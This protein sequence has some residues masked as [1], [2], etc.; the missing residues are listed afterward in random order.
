MRCPPSVRWRS[1]VDPPSGV[2]ST[3]GVD[4]PPRIWPAGAVRPLL[5]PGPPLLRVSRDSHRQVS[6]AGP[7]GHRAACLRWPVETGPPAPLAKWDVPHVLTPSWRLVEVALGLAR[8]P[9]ERSCWFWS[10]RK[11]CL[12]VLLTPDPP[13]HQQPNQQEHASSRHRGPKD[14]AIHCLATILCIQKCSI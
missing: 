1:Q 5:F 10:Y 9:F 3:Q 11:T 13:S 6:A 14:P 2:E 12:L 8:K 4:L 7:V